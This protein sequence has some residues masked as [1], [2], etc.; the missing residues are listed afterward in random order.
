MLKIKNTKK[1]VPTASIVVV[2]A[3]IS[4][5]IYSNFS[6][7]EL[8]YTDKGLQRAAER[9]ESEDYKKILVDKQN[10]EKQQTQTSKGSIVI[11]HSDLTG[12]NLSVAAYVADRTEDGGT[13]YLI[14]QDTD[15]NT[16]TVQTEGVY[17]S[18]TTSCGLLTVDV[19]DFNIAK[20][21]Y[22]IE[23]K[24]NDILIKSETKTVGE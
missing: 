7:K 23:Y 15:Q 21:T 13:C 9:A 22:Y 4:F 2:M 5:A 6:S 12:T 19:A 11:T 10:G 20:A 17:N 1:I 16:S 18:T 3:L 8:I 24:K 14:V